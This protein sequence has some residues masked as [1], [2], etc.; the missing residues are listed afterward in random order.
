MPKTVINK[1][2]ATS[3]G[4]GYT[5][6]DLQPGEIGINYLD[7][8][9]AISIKNSNNEVIPFATSANVHNTITEVKDEILNKPKVL[10]CNASKTETGI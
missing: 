5:P 9:E 8:F 3:T 7:G 6:S 1:H 2:I 4:G 10:I